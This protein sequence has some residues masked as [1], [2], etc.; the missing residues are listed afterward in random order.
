MNEHS[1]LPPS[2]VQRNYHKGVFNGAVFALGEAASNPGLVLSLLV[3]QLG[4]SLTL[5]SLL[6]V[7]QMTGYLLPQLLVGGRIQA[8]TYKLPVYRRFAVLRLIAQCAVVV[9]CFFAGIIPHEWALIAILVSY[10]LFNYGGGVTTLSFQDVVAKTIPVEHRGRFFGTRQLIG[11]LLAFAVGGPLVRWLLSAE[12]P[13]AFPYSFAAIGLFSLLCYAS[14]M[15][16]FATVKEP[17]AERTTPAI[18]MAAAIRGAPLMLRNNPDYRNYILTRLFL[19]VGRLADPFFIIYVTEQLGLPK[20][21]AGVFIATVAVSAAISNIVWGRLGDARGKVWLLRL[22]TTLTV[23]PPLM[24]VLAS[25]VQ[26][27]A[28]DFLV[29]WLLMLSLI[30]GTANDGINI[31]SNTYLLEISPPDERPLYMGLANTL[32]G[33]G[34]VVPIIGGFLVSGIGYTPTFIIAAFFST[35]G[36]LIT[37]LLLKTTPRPTP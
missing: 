35:I 29:V 31:A 19:V 11:G 20:S 24:M 4:G 36:M 16:V 10:A 23:I 2:T 17:P 28:P 30:A 3:R 14:A 15:A 5:V 37:R 21:M 33:I 1:A 12:S 6:P 9:A 32:L 7:I 34:A 26:A 18:S 27:I 22:T 13:L 25:S 8:L